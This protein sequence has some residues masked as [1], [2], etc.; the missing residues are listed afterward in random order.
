MEKSVSITVRITPEIVKALDT[1]ARQ[2]GLSRSMIVRN[3]LTNCDACY[4]YL[5]SEREAQKPEM[6]K[7]EGE[8]AEEVVSTLPDEYSTPKMAMTL[9]RVMRQVAEIMSEKGGDF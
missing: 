4:R 3:L 5:D 8:I 1:L 6:I 9:S 7:L 2:R